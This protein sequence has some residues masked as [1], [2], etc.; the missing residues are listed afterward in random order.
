MISSLLAMTLAAAAPGPS[1]DAIAR[2]RKAYSACL[3]GFMKKSL[4]DKA[5]ETAFATGLTPACAT[6][7][8]A[9]RAAVI[10]ADT[11]SGIKRA[12]AEENATFEIDDLLNNAK[13]MFK[14]HKTNN[15]SP[16]GA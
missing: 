10:A 4:K 16:G 14:D 1:P 3:T 9:F 13:E 6:Q 7:E 15:T 12:A 2:A 11:A 8:Q 5:E